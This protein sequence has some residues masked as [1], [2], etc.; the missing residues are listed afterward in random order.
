VDSLKD[1]TSATKEIVKLV[2]K[3]QSNQDVQA[4]IELSNRLT[5]AQLQTV[6]ATLAEKMNYRKN[7][8]AAAVK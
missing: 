1:C 6:I 2:A 3:E 4:I 7:N 8:P 5:I